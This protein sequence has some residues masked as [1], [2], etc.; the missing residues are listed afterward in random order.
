MTVGIV[1][2]GLIGG[3]VGLAL[4]EPGRTIVGHDPDPEAERVARERFCVDRIAGL[5][6]VAQ[7]DVVFVAAPPRHVVSVLEALRKVKGENTVLTDCTSV[8]GDVVAWAKE[9]KEADFVPGHPMAGHERS[10]AAFASPWMFR[11]ARWLLTPVKSTK[12]AAVRQV[13]TLL[14]AMGATPVRTD[15]ETHDRQVAILSHVPHA[16]A[17]ALVT[18][19]ADLDCMDVGGGSWRDLTRVGGVDPGLW[20]QIFLANRHELARSLG[21]FETTLA[22]LRES[23][24]RDDAQAINAFF[25]R[26]REAKE[27]SAPPTAPAPKAK[28]RTIRKR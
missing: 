5:E 9:T 13:E 6:E 21:D 8:K 4:R 15:A 24:E 18:M 17:G 19:A 28:T 25:E 2:L 23:L 27:R 22:K 10:G 26:A 7:A 11:G 1:G 12:A 20:T 3:S 14:R 16:L